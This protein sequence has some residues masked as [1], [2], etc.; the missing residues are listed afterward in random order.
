MGRPRLLLALCLLSFIAHA[1]QPA[2]AP[3]TASSD[4]DAAPLPDTRQLLLDVERNEKAAEAIRKNYTYHVHFEQQELNGK[5]DPKKLT[6]IDSESLTIDSVRVNRVVA[7]DGRPLTAEEQAKESERID[8]EVAKDK[9]RRDKKEDRGQ[10]TDSR[11]DDIISAARILELGSFTN[12]RRIELNGR[13]TIVLDYAGDPN[14]KTRSSF[15]GVIRNLVGTVWID[16]KD[17]VLVQAEGHFLKDFKIGAGLVADVKKDSS[18]SAHWAHINNEVWLPTLVDGQGK[19]RILLVT[20]FTGR[21][22]LVTS[23]YRKFRTTATIV[24]GGNQVDADGNPVPTSS[25]PGDP[26]PPKP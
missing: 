19:V 10:E 1:Q 14:A 15:E 26:K 16:E 21:I 11:G 13:P 9:S 17:R 22:H 25:K 12:P 8:K 7:R 4:A 24:S 2:S 5:G 6:A 23:D 18:F 20:G 3:L